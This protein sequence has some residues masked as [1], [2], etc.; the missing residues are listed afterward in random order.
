MDLLLEKL[1][2]IL[3]LILLGMFLRKVRL[4]SQE[5]IEGLKQI[6]I[7]VA[8]PGILF[9]AFS[10]MEL[11]TE[12]ILLFALVFVFC[13][14]LYGLGELARKV[15]PRLFQSSYTSGYFTGFEFGMIG[16]GLFSAIWGM[17]KLPVIMMVGFGHELFIWF[18]YMPL[19]SA[20]G[21]HKKNLIMVLKSFI[22]NPP[23]IG[24]AT[25]IIFNVLDIYVALANT[26]IGS[27]IYS[28]IG[29]LSPL[30]SPLILI[31]IGYS[32]TLGR[33]KLKELAAYLLA[34]WILVLSIGSGVLWLVLNFIQDL[35][36]LFIV[37]FYAFIILP[38]PYL[39][40]L[41]IDRKEE[42]EFFSQLLIYSTIV[43]FVAYV[44][45]LALSL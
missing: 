27:S 6:I 24:I 26:L 45:L 2:P 4:I 21:E 36:P 22:K 16:V 9:T 31:V 10:T 5:T 19:I 32:M 37:A 17:D 39:L 23:I 41:L 40:P 18:V 29:F 28:T 35:D 3:L 44:V 34:R 1:L 13:F 30:T 15:M 8:L 11:E 38:P 20:K 12:Y 33:V 14:I 43:S 25:G 7:K 42:E